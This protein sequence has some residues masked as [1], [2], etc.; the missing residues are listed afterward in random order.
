MSTSTFRLASRTAAA[1][2]ST[3][4][5]ERG[6]RV[7]R[8]EAERGRDQAGEHGERPGEVAAEV[9]RVGEE[10]VAPVEARAAQR[11]HR[12]RRVDHEHEPDRGERPPR[13]L[14]LELDHARKSQDRRDGDADADEDEEPG[15]GERRE[16]LCLR[17]ARTDGL[18]RRDEPR[19][20]RRRT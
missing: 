11:D 3:G 4:H 7:A 9:E 13:R 6:D 14:D 16:I 2:T 18:D 5:E 1:T 12:S 10:R 15:L 20:R 8:G 17:R 19:P